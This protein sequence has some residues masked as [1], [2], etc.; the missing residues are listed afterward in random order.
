MVSKCIRILEN[1]KI[2]VKCK[3]LQKLENFYLYDSRNIV[4]NHKYSRE[5]KK[6]SSYFRTA[7]NDLGKCVEI[8][9]LKSIKNKC[10]FN[11]NK[12]NLVK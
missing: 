8:N 5:I 7:F 3:F 11:Q 2:S 10:L 6:S 9:E 1:S 4:H 12:L